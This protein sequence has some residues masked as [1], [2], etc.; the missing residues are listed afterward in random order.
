MPTYEYRAKEGPGNTI[1]GEL[2]A[3]S[4]A[5]A[6]AKVEA[7]G[8]SPVWV[9]EKTDSGVGRMMRARRISRRD[10]AVFTR[11]LASLI[12]SGVPILKALATTR[13]QT[14]SR[15]FSRVLEDIERE[16]R[17]GKMLSEALTAYPE[18]FP[19]LYVNMIRSGES[20]GVLDVM[21]FRL[22][23]AFEREDDMRRK[24]QAAI[25]YPALII[26]VGVVTV[27][28]LLTFF[29]PRVIQLFQSYRHK[30]LPLP[31]RILLHISDFMSH[32]WYWI[33]IILVLL[34]AVYRRLAML[35]KGKTMIDGMK[36]RLPLAG[37]F[38]R[39]VEIARFAR[40]LS[41]LVNAGISID[42]A[43]LLSMGALRNVVM[44]NE[45]G[46]ARQET[47]QQGIPLSV[48]LRHKPNFPPLV[49]NMMA[50]GEQTGSIDESLN[51][52]A[53]FYEKEIEQQSRLMTSLLEPILILVVGGVVGFIVSAMLLPIFELSTS[54]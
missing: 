31:T 52:V 30:A 5:A 54:F 33:V 24:I 53:A 48:G 34:F 1:D 43:L 45:V 37:R 46:E 18:L 29:L 50:V 20:A 35:D 38:I 10:V 9:R 49:S 47:V 23:D 6:L 42:R 44:R 4:R 28:I 26:I 14:E 3:E 40:T 15:L 17:G 2:S 25:A 32:D 8:Y 36:L 41:L 21:L 7:M 27:F 12:K 13:D 22:A 19:D 39:H 51:E 11:Q 16:T